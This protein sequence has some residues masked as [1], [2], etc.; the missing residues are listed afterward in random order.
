L[1][2][3]ALLKFRNVWGILIV[4]FLCAAAI[5]LD[6]PNLFFMFPIGIYALGKV[7]SF[8]KLRSKVSL[9]ANLRKVLTVLI[10]I[11][12]IAFFLW[13]NQA[14]YGNPFRLSGTLQTA[15]SQAPKD[16]A[17][18]SALK[19]LKKQT[20]NRNPLAFFKTRNLLNGFYIH[21]VSPDRGIIYYAPVVL[22][23]IV[24]FIL[25]LKKKVKMV[26]LLFAIIGANILLYSMWG[27]PYGGWAFGSRYL[28][29]TY[30]ILSIFVALLLTYWQKRLLFLIAFV[31]IAFYS[32]AVNT[33]GAITTSAM[34]PKVEVLELEKVSH[35][36][37]KYTYARNWDY[38]ATGHSKSFFYQTF[39]GSYLTTVQFYEILVFSICA[40]ISGLIIGSYLSQKKGVS[41]NV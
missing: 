12:P 29:P 18:T 26:P 6:Y 9:K 1:S 39:L 40:V 14:S 15:S 32:I 11:I 35:M 28:I 31:I 4:F 22:I 41:T 33:L 5:P 38:L 37:Q 30:A 2:I 7:F 8:S 3:Y 21:L 20:E 27:D 16:L 23:G 36:V 34:P 19:T 25:A 24:G 17:S 10:M 13:F